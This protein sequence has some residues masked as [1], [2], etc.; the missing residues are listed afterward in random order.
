MK[1]DQFP[2]LNTANDLYTLG[3]NGLVQAENCDI[4][5]N[6]AISRRP[7]RAKV[8]TGVIDSAWGDG[9]DFLFVE[10]TELKQLNSDYSATTL[11][12]LTEA[13]GELYVLRSTTNKL[14]WSTGY[15]HG[16][17]E[18]GINRDWIILDD[19]Y[20]AGTSD[21]EVLV[22]QLHQDPMPVGKQMVEFSG[23]IWMVYEDMVIYTNPYSETTDLREN[24]IP[25]GEHITNLGAVSDG[26]FVTTAERSYF[27]SGRNPAE[28]SVVQ[29]APYGAIPN[30]MLQ[31]DG[32][33]LGEGQNTLGLIW[34][35]SQGICAGFPNG[36]LV[37]ITRQQIK[38][39]S[40]TNGTA[41]LRELNGQKHY[42]AV[43][44][45]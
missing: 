37:N 2:G 27:Y 26:L 17:I 28:M 10:G 8:Y 30:T 15:Q 40:G 22:D 14:Y 12:S 29:Q 6:G 21:A 41:L 7:G 1:L 11:V 35:S 39:L 18:A 24:F 4:D 42:I 5:R 34:T 13:T 36:S 44:Q 45:D 19:N 32:R 23:C 20:W 38:E 31:I 25:V 16:V 9:Q 43:L 33:V 3:L